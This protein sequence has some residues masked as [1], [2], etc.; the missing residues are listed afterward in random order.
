[1]I[2]LQIIGF[3]TVGSHCVVVAE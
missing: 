2:A 3:V 1:M